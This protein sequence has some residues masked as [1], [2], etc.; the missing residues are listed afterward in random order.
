MQQIL[1]VA[2]I[3]NN[4]WIHIDSLV[5]LCFPELRVPSWLRV[6][7]CRVWKPPSQ[8]LLLVRR[9]HLI[10]WIGPGKG[11]LCF[12]WLYLFGA[13]MSLLAIS[14][15]TSEALV[16]LWGQDGDSGALELYH[17]RPHLLSPASQSSLETWPKIYLPHAV[18]TYR[19]RNAGDPCISCPHTP[20]V[21]L[22]D[23]GRVIRR[24]QHRAVE[25]PLLHTWISCS[26]YSKRVKFWSECIS[27]NNLAFSL[28]RT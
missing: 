7:K 17:A 25:L 21:C 11:L 23:S 3:G 13:F 5:N 16:L 22:G 2:L 19:E 20:W 6:E 26:K 15:S 1:D 18:F 28:T 24:L 12:S 27:S 10:P 9:I 14:P 4:R 8:F